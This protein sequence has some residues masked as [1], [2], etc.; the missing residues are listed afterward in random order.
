[1]KNFTFM[2]KSGASVLFLRNLFSYLRS[3]TPIR[4]MQYFPGFNNFGGHS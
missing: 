2:S 1:M 3:G 4:N